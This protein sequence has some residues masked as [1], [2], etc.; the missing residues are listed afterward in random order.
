MKKILRILRGGFFGFLVYCMLIVF[1]T[2]LVTGY[3]DWEFVIV[4]WSLPLSFVAW[5]SKRWLHEMPNY[6]ILFMSFGDGLIAFGAWMGAR[7]SLVRKPPE[8]N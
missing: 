8:S 2:R 7:T 3:F 5:F 6:S 4:C 1:V